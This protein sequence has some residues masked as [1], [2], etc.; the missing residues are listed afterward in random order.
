[1]SVTIIQWAQL[2]VAT[3]NTLERMLS[4]AEV[5]KLDK[6]DGAEYTTRPDFDAVRKSWAARYRELGGDLKSPEVKDPAAYLDTITGVNANGINSHSFVP[7][8]VLVQEPS[9]TPVKKTKPKPAPKRQ[10][11]QGRSMFEAD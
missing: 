3:A 7:P 10:V 11:I 4:L 2:A 5:F 6:E 8:G 9:C 1:M